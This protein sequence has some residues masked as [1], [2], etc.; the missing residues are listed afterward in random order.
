MLSLPFGLN[1][2]HDCVL[3]ATALC[4]AMRVSHSEWDGVAVSLACNGLDSWFVCTDFESL[5]SSELAVLQTY[6]YR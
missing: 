1:A 5:Q 4:I 6:C 3:N 2:I